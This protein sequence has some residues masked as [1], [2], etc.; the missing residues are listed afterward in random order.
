MGVGVRLFN[1]IQPAVLIL[2]VVDRVAFPAV[3][4]YLSQ[5]IDT[6][7]NSTTSESCPVV[8]ELKYTVIEFFKTLSIDLNGWHSGPVTPYLSLLISY[9]PTKY[10][11]NLKNI[12]VLTILKSAQ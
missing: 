8:L 9:Q 1:H 5:I 2:A 12:Y 7:Y 6:T 3:H 11:I 10:K 4:K